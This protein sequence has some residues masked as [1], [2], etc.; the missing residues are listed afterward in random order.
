MKQKVQI[1]TVALLMAV[2][3]LGGQSLSAQTPIASQ[4]AIDAASTIALSYDPFAL[5][6][7]ASSST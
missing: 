6:A 2:G 7:T 5:A 1:S 4:E 3:M